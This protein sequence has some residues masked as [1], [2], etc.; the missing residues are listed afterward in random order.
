MK[1]ILFQAAVFTVIL[2]GLYSCKLPGT[3]Q[4]LEKNVCTGIVQHLDELNHEPERDRLISPVGSTDNKVEFK[5]N[6]EVYLQLK[7]NQVFNITQLQQQH[8][9]SGLKSFIKEI[10]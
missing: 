3:L 1:K 2:I 7:N 8:R 6:G 9:L 10:K 4:S 5:E